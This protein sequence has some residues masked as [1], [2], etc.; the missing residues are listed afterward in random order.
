MVKLLI[1]DDELAYS[2]SLINLLREKY[3]LEVDCALSANEGLNKFKKYKDSYSVVML[4]IM[5]AIEETFSPREKD[6]SDDGLAT[7]KI[8]YE[9]I[10]KINSTIPIIVLTARTDVNMQFFGSGQKLKTTIMYKPT[11]AED[12]VKSINKLI[13]K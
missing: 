12:I 7:G 9:K 1:I 6:R 5:M 11:S 4:D 3:A 13:D 2:L 8:I 10:R